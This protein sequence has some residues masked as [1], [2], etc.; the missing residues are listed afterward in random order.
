MT[1]AIDFLVHLAP[2]IDPRV[3]T[4][5]WVIVFVI[6]SVRLV[7]IVWGRPRPLLA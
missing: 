7:Q 3:I 4:A 1:E 2:F 5:A 6:V